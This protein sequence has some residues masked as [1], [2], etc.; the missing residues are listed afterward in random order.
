M[1]TKPFVMAT[2]VGAI[3]LSVSG[4]AVFALA[5]P[6]FYADFMH[7]GP[8]TGVERQPMLFWPIA[9]GMLSYSALL[10]LVIGRGDRGADVRAGVKIGAI[11][12]ALLWITADF[13]LY[14]M[15]N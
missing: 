10:T 11:V 12:S 3:T 14:G 7:G 8:A 6:S 9:V 15:S 2:L 1:T 4:Y 5:F 13:M